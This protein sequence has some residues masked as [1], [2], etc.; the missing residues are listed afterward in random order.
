MKKKYVII[1]SI[2]LVFFMSLIASATA[3]ESPGL[4]DDGK[5]KVP[6]PPSSGGDDEN[7]PHLLLKIPELGPEPGIPITP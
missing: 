3:I 4:P 7:Q 6:F 5:N 1:A 2:T